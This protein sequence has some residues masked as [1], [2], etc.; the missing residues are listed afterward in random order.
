MIFQIF[1]FEGKNKHDVFKASE[2]LYYIFKLNYFYNSPLREK[3]ISFE[4]LEKFSSGPGSRDFAGRGNI[5]P[6]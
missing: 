4:L 5:A 1:I 6:I 3:N 2:Y